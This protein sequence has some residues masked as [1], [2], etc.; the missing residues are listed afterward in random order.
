MAHPLLS[1]PSILYLSISYNEK[2]YI[3][4]FRNI[5]SLFMPQIPVPPTYADRLKVIFNSA[6]DKI[7]RT[8]HL[9]ETLKRQENRFETYITI[10]NFTLRYYG[11]HE[12][13]ATAMEAAAIYY[14]LKHITNVQGYKIVD[15]NFTTLA[16]LVS[17]IDTWNA[18]INMF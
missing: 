14:S 7:H 5:M 15:L 4:G 16:K 18:R 10:G 6:V 11:D 1:F 12:K 13:T 9:I 2:N 8:K 3:I 17:D